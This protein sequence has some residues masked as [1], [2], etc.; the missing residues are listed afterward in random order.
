[1]STYLQLDQHKVDSETQIKVLGVELDTKLHQ[2]LYIQK[3]QE[4][5]T[6][7][8]MALH[9]ITTSTQGAMFKRAKLVY[10]AVVQPAITYATPIQFSLAGAEATKNNLID[11]LDKIQNRCL[12]TIAGAYKAIPIPLLESETDTLSMRTHLLMLQ[13]QYQACTKDHLMRALVKKACKRIQT[14]LQGQRGCQRIRKTTS[15]NQKEA[16]FNSLPIDLMSRQP[17]QTQIR[18]WAQEQQTKAWEEHQDKIPLDKHSIAYKTR[19]HSSIHKGL[20]RAESSLATQLRTEKTGLRAFLHD[21]KVPGVTATCTCRHPR[22]TVKHVML[23]CLDRSDRTTFLGRLGLIDFHY[24]LANKDT[25][26]KALRWFLRQELLPQFQL[27]LP[28]LTA[29]EGRAQRA[30]VPNRDQ[31]TQR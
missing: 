23:Y 4:K 26:R 27:A 25:L 22:Q 12:R 24:I 2:D 29:I 21:C 18:K 9:R 14:Q 11:K 20:T 19:I 10:I 28:V 16:W 1:M 13:A 31:E 15:G 17:V 6:Q 3:I 8:A 30:I 5:I 7:Q